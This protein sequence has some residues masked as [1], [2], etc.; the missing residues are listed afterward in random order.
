MWASL[1]HFKIKRFRCGIMIIGNLALFGQQ[2]FWHNYKC[3]RIY[4]WHCVINTP[5][6]VHITCMISLSV[7]EYVWQLTSISCRFNWLLTKHSTLCSSMTALTGSLV[8]WSFCVCK[9]ATWWCL[10]YMPQ[11][12][13]MSDGSSEWPYLTATSI[14]TSACVAAWPS[15]NF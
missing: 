3:H 13:W 2:W 8:L 11:T 15:Q 4:A 6:G 12:C 14:M 5:L 10:W 7:Q 9:T 1:N